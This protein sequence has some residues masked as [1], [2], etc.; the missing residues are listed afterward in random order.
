VL[1]P[2]GDYVLQVIQSDVKEAKSGNGLNLELVYE[3][4]EGPCA[5]RRVYDR[6]NNIAHSNAQAQ[7]IG[8]RPLKRLC[9]ALNLGPITDS[10]TL[11]FKPFRGS[12]RVEKG[13]PGYDDKNVVK[14]FKPYSPQTAA[15]PQGRGAVVEAAQPQAQTEAAQPQQRALGG[16]GRPWAR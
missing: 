12:V 2:E 3:V 11:H 16:G 13:D 5:K 1:L 14:G 6:M 4:M 15:T 10:D 8:Q 7:E 9:E